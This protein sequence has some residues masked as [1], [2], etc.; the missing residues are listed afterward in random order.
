MSDYGL[1]EYSRQVRDSST[2]EQSQH[3]DDDSLFSGVGASFPPEDYK[4][5]Q[6]IRRKLRKQVDGTYHKFLPIS[7]LHEIMQH[8]TVVGFLRS[9]L[10]VSSW[11]NI[12]SI[13]TAICG[14]LDAQNDDHES[15]AARRV[16][17]ILVHLE[18]PNEIVA[19][20]NDGICD[21]DLPLVR[22]DEKHGSYGLKRDPERHPERPQ[23]PLACFEPWKQ[24][25]REDFEIY[26]YWMTAPF[27]AMK[28]GRS[29]RYKFQDWDVLPFTA[30]EDVNVTPHSI[31]SRVE[32]HEAHHKLPAVGMSSSLAVPFVAPC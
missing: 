27:F 4:L 20:I 9:E 30:Q 26:Q 11:S 17:A 2:A 5:G 6:R 25:D 3:H 29:R 22:A 8:E 31:V 15:K 13:V 21:G 7:D 19:L 10:P 23:G 16:F 32:I 28:N 18:M 14:P 12:P 1:S 24:R